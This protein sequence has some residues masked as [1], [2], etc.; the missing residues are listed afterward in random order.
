MSNLKSLVDPKLNADD[1]TI[2]LVKREASEEF[3]GFVSQ[4]TPFLRLSAK[5]VRLQRDL[6]YKNSSSRQSA[7]IA[8]AFPLRTV[9]PLLVQPGVMRFEAHRFARNELRLDAGLGFERVAI[10]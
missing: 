7:S 8:A 6:A 10:G 5:D 4:K 1:V 9:F 2:L 3:V